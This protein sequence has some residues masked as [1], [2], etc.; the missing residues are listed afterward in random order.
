[1]AMGLMEKQ[2]GQSGGESRKGKRRQEPLLWLVLEGIAQVG[3]AGQRLA[4][5]NNFSGIRGVS[6]GGQGREQKG[7]T[8][9]VGKGL[10][11]GGGGSELVG[12]YMNLQHELFTLLGKLYWPEEARKLGRMLALE[13]GSPSVPSRPEEMSNIRKVENKKA[14]LITPI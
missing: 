2:Q 11:G 9:E 13:G 3:S 12:L 7:P 8:E 5:L 6:P 14:W 1:M 10:G 4:G